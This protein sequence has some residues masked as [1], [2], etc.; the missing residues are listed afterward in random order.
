MENLINKSKIKET[1]DLNVASDFYEHL[2]KVL[3]ELIQKA[4]ERAKANG[5]KTL[6]PMDL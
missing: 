6:K 3:H 1:T 4:S 5:R 2:N